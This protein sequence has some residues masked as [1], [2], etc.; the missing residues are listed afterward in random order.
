MTT[1]ALR[2]LACILPERILRTIRLLVRIM[3]R[4]NMRIHNAIKNAENNRRD[5]ICR[6][7]LEVNYNEIY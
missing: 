6:I 5:G 7:S 4:K 3:R 1:F 2:V